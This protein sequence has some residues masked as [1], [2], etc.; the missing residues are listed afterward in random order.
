[1]PLPWTVHYSISE[2]DPSGRPLP[3]IRNT[4]IVGEAETSMEAVM[5]AATS[6]AE[7][8]HML[9]RYEQITFSVDGR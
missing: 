2:K 4:V 1:M 7:A 9:G 5:K 6:L 8:G 3:P